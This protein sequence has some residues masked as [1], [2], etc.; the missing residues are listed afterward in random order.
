MEKYEYERKFWLGYLH[1]LG[2]FVKCPF[3]SETFYFIG[4]LIY[5]WKFIRCIAVDILTFYIFRPSFSI[6]HPVPGSS[7][8]SIVALALTLTNTDTDI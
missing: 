2:K 6:Q 5:L 4:D 3:K 8:Y 1:I 7:E